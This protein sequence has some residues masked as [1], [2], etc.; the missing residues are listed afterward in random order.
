M[1]NILIFI[2][3]NVVSF[4]LNVYIQYFVKKLHKSSFQRLITSSNLLT[5]SVSFV[6]DGILFHKFE[7]MYDKLSNP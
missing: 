3:I 1:N 5:E 4:L 6:R 7:R 2:N